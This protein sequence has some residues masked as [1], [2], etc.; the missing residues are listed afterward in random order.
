MAETK[1]AQPQPLRL[2]ATHLASLLAD[3]PLIVIHQNTI[4]GVVVPLE[5]PIQFARGSTDELIVKT[6]IELATEAA[7]ALKN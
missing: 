7:D 6:Y 5:T 3:Q 2:K 4:L 1:L